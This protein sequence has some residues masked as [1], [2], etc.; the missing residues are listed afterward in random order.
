MHLTD[1]QLNEYLDNEIQDRVQIELHLASCDECTARLTVLRSLFN[2]IESLPDLALSHNI[3]AVFTRQSSQPVPQLPRWLTLTATLQAAIAA[4]ALVI[5]APLVMQWISPY[6]SNM[7]G[8]SFVELFFELQSQWMVW[9]DMFSQFQIPSVPEIPV[10][11]LSSMLIL[12]TVAGVSTLW[13][14]G[15][16]LLLRNQFK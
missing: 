1:E 2:E 8:P 11:E 13:I 9:L 6:L 5:A 15:N 14:V 4:V 10:L 12:L 16:G 3:A 7:Q